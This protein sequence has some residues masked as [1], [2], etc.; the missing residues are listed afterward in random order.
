MVLVAVRTVAIPPHVMPDLMRHL[1]TYV[2]PTP[3]SLL[4]PAPEGTDYLRRSNFARRMWKPA[5]L[6]VD[7]SCTSTIFATPG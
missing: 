1:E 2:G 5:T 6:R 7:V 4:F 3:D